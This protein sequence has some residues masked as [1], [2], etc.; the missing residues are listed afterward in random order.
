MR[1]DMKEQHHSFANIA[2]SETETLMPSDRNQRI[3]TQI[4]D[5][6]GWNSLSIDKGEEVNDP[7]AEL[8]RTNRSVWNIVL[9]VSAESLA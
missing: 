9:S 3:L 6:E 4:A 8:F 7:V 1:L 2:P 5:R